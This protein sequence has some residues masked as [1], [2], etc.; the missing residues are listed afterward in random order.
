MK[1]VFVNRFAWPDHSATSQMLSDL[2]FGLARTGYGVGVITSRQRYDDPGAELP[3]SETV[4][5]VAICRIWTSRFGRGRMAGR[6][7]DYLT[8]YASA[9]IAVLRI[10]R[11]G[12]V[13]V[14]KTDPPLL[15]VVIGPVARMR[16]AFVVNWW[17]DVFPEVATA[18]GVRGFVGML[19]TT[20]R[21]LRN[22]S[23][24]RAT[25]N[26]AIGER[27]ARHLEAQ[28]TPRTRIAIIHNWADGD[29]VT[30]VD[31]ESNSLRGR[32]G[33][34]GKFVVGYSGNLGRVHDSK[35]LIDAADR[36]RSD[37]DIVFLFIG[38]GHQLDAMRR[39]IASRGLTDRFMFLPYQ[40]REELRE[41]LGVPDVHWLSLRPELEGLVVPSKLYGILAAGRPVIMVGAADGE[42][43]AIVRAA[44]CGLCVEQGDGAGLAAAIAR[45]RSESG[46]RGEMGGNARQLLTARFD[47]ALALQA[48]RRCLGEAGC[49]VDPQG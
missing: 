35:T 23:L 42:V 6:A 20:A 17:Q 44:G 21:A 36:L 32:W 5:G 39:D 19:G 24:R 46:Q 41:S 1:I 25:M 7:L 11:R 37:S 29:A 22:G 47:K 14:V 31:S 33:L 28:G 13:V 30:P 40:P 18:L 27:M 10:V 15:S 45:L 16:G 48:W 3:A 34:A 9:A 8:F 43:G 26:V 12:D 2:A 4:D 38:G 49:G